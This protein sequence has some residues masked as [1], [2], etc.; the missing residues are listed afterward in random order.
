MK[1]KKHG[2]NSRRKLYYEFWDYLDRDN[3]LLAYVR[4]DTR[5]GEFRV[6]AN[7]AEDRGVE[8]PYHGCFKTCK[9]AKEH[10]IAYFVNK[11]LEEA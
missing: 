3:N 2:R 9:E 8:P 5:K 1:W 6:F 10:I 7:E 4:H 11:R